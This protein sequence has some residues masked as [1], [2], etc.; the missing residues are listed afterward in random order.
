MFDTRV[1]IDDCYPYTSG[2]GVTGDCLLGSSGCP[3]GTGSNEKYHAASA[4][5]VSSDN[6]MQEIYEN[7][8]VEAAYMVYQDFYAYQQGV[9]EHVSGGLVG[10]H[11]VKIIGWGALNGTPYW[12]RKFEVKIYEWLT[13]GFY[14]VGCQF[15]GN[16]LGRL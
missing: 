4:Y 7:G 12:V 13:F 11:A 9:Y 10:G 16:K 1:V 5:S 3:S 6:I 8:P 14:L 2:N 15:L